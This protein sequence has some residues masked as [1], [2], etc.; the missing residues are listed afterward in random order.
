MGIIKTARPLHRPL[1]WRLVLL[2]AGLPTPPAVAAAAGS[3]PSALERPI[4][5]GAVFVYGSLSLGGTSRH[6]AFQAGYGL[7]LVFRPHA[8]ADLWRPLFEWNT[9]IVVEAARR[10]VASD[11]RLLSGQLLLRHYGRDWR[12][13]AVGASP[14]LGAGMGIASAT[15]PR[16]AGEGD[17]GTAADKW[18]MPLFEAGWEL[19]PDGASLFMVCARYHVYRHAGLDYTGWSLHLGAGIPAPW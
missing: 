3:P 7:G 6:D 14:F 12:R 2:A 19:S 5:P 4:G 15:Y 16:D 17:G 9:A 18:F 1:L 13:A 10:P 8:A 11:R